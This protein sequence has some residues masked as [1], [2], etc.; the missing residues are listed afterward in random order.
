MVVGYEGKYFRTAIGLLDIQH[1]LAV[2][3]IIDDF[4]FDEIPFLEISSDYKP[5]ATNVA[6]SGYPLGNYLLNQIHEPTYSEGIIGIQ[7][8]IDQLRKN[9][10]ISGTVVGGY[11][12]SPVIEKSTGQVIGVVADGPQNA[13]IFMAVSFEHINALIKLSN[14]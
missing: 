10:Q 6:W 2:L 13:G 11:S 14:S 5:V 4:N 3:K 12:G 1:D 7:K 8:R 9:I